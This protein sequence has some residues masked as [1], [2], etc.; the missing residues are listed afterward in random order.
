VTEGPPSLS[1]AEPAADRIELRGLRLTGTHGLL[2]EERDRAQPFEIDIDIEMDLDSAVDTDQLRYTADYAA[3]I[4]AVATVV[5]GPHSDLMEHLAGRLVE[6][7]RA[8]APGAAAVSVSVRKL[9]PPVPFDVASAGV[10][11]RRTWHHPPPAT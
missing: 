5:Q 6:T 1:Q 7:V 11:I 3:V 4:D 2:P 9:R 8:Q 10:T